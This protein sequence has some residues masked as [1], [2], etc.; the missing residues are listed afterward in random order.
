MGTNPLKLLLEAPKTPLLRSTGFKTAVLFGVLAVTAVWLALSDLSPDLSH[1]DVKVL[2]GNER[3]NYY[4]IVTNLAT[5]AENKQGRVTNVASL[6]SVDNVEQLVA[7][8]R[9]CEV[10]LALVQDGLDWPSGHKLELV[11]RLSKS[12]T[13]FFLGKSADQIKTYADLRGKRIGIGS[14]GSGADRIARQLFGTGAL[15]TLEVTLENHTLEEQLARLESGAL[16]LGVLVIDEDATLV[17][18]AVRVRGLQ[19]ASF[20]NADVIARK[21]PF[22]RV[23]RIGAGQYDPLRML[24]PEDKRVL[25]VGTLIV[26]NGCASRSE[27]QSFMGL[28]ATVFPDFVRHNRD[29]PNMTGLPL[30]PAARTYFDNQGPDVVG[31]YAPWVID[32]MPTASWIQ[33]LFGISILFNVM[34]F[35]HKFRL[36]R[37]DANRV[38]L[39][40]FLPLI[41]GPTWTPAEIASQEPT[42]VHRER[43]TRDR[44]DAAI[45]RFQALADTA[46]AQSLSVL[47]PMG[48]EMSYRYQEEIIERTLAAL[49][50]FRSKLG[51]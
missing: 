49:R 8:K 44:L 24:P 40:G 26:G 7:A 50:Q 46:R 10:E 6:G 15:R 35:W 20:Q 38:R 30:S 36:W 43:A 45:G 31:E 17:E 23:G 9:S 51:Q 29:T 12:E 3:G 37:I 27:L 25:R 21:L 42:E 2:S 22:A 33:L 1:L 41:F 16:D 14:T 18:E 32:V 11:G 19:I 4:S 13:V 48:Q 28:I 34:T 5:E 47:V 39:E